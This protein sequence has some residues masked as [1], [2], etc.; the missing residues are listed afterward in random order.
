MQNYINISLSVNSELTDTA[1]AF[2]SLYNTD[3]IEEREGLLVVCFREENWN[4]ETRDSLV[5]TMKMVSP[6]I[7]I[8]SEEKVA[9]QNWN[10]IWEK[11]VPVI[12]VTDTVGIAP[13]RKIDQLNTKIKI[14]I[15]PKMSFGTGTHPSTRLMCRM[16]EQHIAPGTTW[17]DVGCGTGV[18]AVLAV[19]LG[20]AKVIAFDNNEWAI[21]NSKENFKLNDVETAVELYDWDIDDVEL[22]LADGILANINLDIILNSLPKFTK[23]LRKGSGLL[24]VSGILAENEE[25]VI[26]KAKSYAL[27]HV[28]TM[29][30]EEWV[31]ITFRA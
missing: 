18:L 1:V 3:G 26:E 9:E 13:S 12:V 11:E 17:L 24:I 6:D 23:S 28:E 22:P 14:E 30:D 31:S 8:V 15:N 21:E 5:N 7:A 29:D 4:G 20:A 2:L 25:E 16:M 10:E 19:R 27:T